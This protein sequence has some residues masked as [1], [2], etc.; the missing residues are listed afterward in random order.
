M[1]IVWE[2]LI[3]GLRSTVT[4]AFVV[5]PLMIILEIARANNWLEQII[6]Y[7]YPPFRALGLSKEGTFPVLVAFIFGLIYG[8][9]VIINNVREGKLNPVEIQIIGVFSALC[10]SVFEDSFIFM[11][12]G[13]PGWILIVPR[14][15]IAILSSLAIYHYHRWRWGT[16]LVEESLS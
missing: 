6:G 10:H 7:I 15:V 12:I 14:L 11:A 4:I 1:S 16:T 8:S 9:G 3:T 5:I 2:G 13:V